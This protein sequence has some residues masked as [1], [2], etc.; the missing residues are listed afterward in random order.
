M[1]TEVTAKLKKNFEEPLKSEVMVRK[2]VFDEQ[3]VLVGLYGLNENG[4]WIKKQ[5]GKSYPKL[6]LQV[7][8]NFTKDGKAWDVLTN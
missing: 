4:E 2:A 7:Y 6:P 3:N 1:K 8:D 5:E